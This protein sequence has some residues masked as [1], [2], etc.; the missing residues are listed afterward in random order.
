MSA[1]SEPGA[2]ER[3]SRAIRLKD[4]LNRMLAL[5]KNMR[6][7]LESELTD[8]ASANFINREFVG[9]L[10]DVTQ[11]YERLTNASI[12]LAKAEKLLEEQLTPEQERAAVRTFVLTNMEA[13]ERGEFIQ[14]LWESHLKRKD[15]SKGGR[16]VVYNKL[17]TPS[18]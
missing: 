7:R 17:R 14:A 3:Q 1:A 18:E 6:E 15:P 2:D 8:A 12:N 10:K 13:T 9:K 16:P 5:V 4:E 11:S